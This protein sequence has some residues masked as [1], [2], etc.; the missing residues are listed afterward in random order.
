MKGKDYII[1]GNTIFFT[2]TFNRP[3]CLF[4]DVPTHVTTLAFDKNSSFNQPIIFNK[5]MRTVTFYCKFIQPIVLSSKIKVLEI[6]TD[7]YNIFDNIPKL[8]SI[9]MFQ[10]KLYL[11]T[12]ISDNPIVLSKNIYFGQSNGIIWIN[13]FK[14]NFTFVQTN[15]LDNI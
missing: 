15:I 1:D 13:V 5:K 4:R 3:L 10:T 8:S 11:Y 7:N 14:Q 6:G 2:K 9:S 12:N